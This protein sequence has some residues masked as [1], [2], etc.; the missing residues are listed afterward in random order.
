MTSHAGPPAQPPESWNVRHSGIEACGVTLVYAVLGTKPRASCTHV[1]QAL[2]PLGCIP[3]PQKSAFRTL[4]PTTLFFPQH[5]ALLPIHYSSSCQW[6]P[7]SRHFTVKTFSILHGFSY[8]KKKKKSLIS[9]FFTMA[10]LSDS[11][12]DRMCWK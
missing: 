10:S 4:S 7:W 5:N 1:R 9:P 8:F 6:E 11:A 3:H 12:M 2:Y